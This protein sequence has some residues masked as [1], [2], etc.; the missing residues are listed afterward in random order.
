MDHSLEVKKS[1]EINCSVQTVWKV[2]TD[3]IHIAKYLHGTETITDWETGSNI[4]FQGEYEGQQY[5][6]KGIV[7]SNIPNKELSY[8]YFS[9][10]SGLE[11]KEENYSLVQ[12]NF[13]SI[14]ENKCNLT[15]HQIGYPDATRK[16]HSE[17][18]MD[19][20]LK[21]IKT[22]AESI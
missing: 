4:I 21:Q 13:S 8:R 3:P 11:D 15:W 14:D 19:E 10:F 6:D 5:K 2:M 20:L 18:G 9:G 16:E 1:I 12:Y 22:I 17:N 7:K